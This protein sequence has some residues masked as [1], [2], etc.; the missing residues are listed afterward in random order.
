MLHAA[1]AIAAGS[2]ALPAHALE[3]GA[4]NLRSALG[5]R[6]LVEIPITS[7]LPLPAGC[8]D[9]RI[10]SPGSIL[11]SAGQR[12]LPGGLVLST[13]RIVAEPVLALSVT[14][15]CPGLPKLNREYTLFLDP[16]ARGGELKPSVLATARSTTT[17]R[18]RPAAIT[19]A[20]ARSYRVRSGDTVSA[21]AATLTAPGQSFWPMVDRIVSANPEAFVDGLLG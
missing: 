7:D 17:R 13:P 14:V 19:A 21:I 3:L 1:I 2:L 16:A 6:L 8:I 12:P 4:A 15:S 9:A 20:T 5:E 18:R 11:K 10:G